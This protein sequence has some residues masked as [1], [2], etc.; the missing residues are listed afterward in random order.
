MNLRRVDYYYFKQ[1]CNFKNY[2]N[3]SIHDWDTR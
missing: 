1:F 2:G 3:S